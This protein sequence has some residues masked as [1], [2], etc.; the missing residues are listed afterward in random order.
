MGEDIAAKANDRRQIAEAPLGGAA[1][2]NISTT[3]ADFRELV[4]TDAESK[5]SGNC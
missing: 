3:G 5:S 4:S 1:V 2:S